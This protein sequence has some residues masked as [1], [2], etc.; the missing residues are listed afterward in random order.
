MHTFLL[1]LCELLLYSFLLLQN[2]QSKIMPE[3]GFR[4]NNVRRI[5]EESHIGERHE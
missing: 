4:L 1:W 5:I 3:Q 2:P